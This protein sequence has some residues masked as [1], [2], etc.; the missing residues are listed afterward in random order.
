MLENMDYN[1]LPM[2]IKRSSSTFSLDSTIFFSSDCAIQMVG[3]RLELHEIE[4]HP[5]YCTIFMG[6]DPPCMVLG[7]ESCIML[8]T[9]EGRVV[10]K[11]GNPAVN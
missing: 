7:Q 10:R 8:L 9:P 4:E 11:P 2:Y 6:I 5:S 3:D 1:G